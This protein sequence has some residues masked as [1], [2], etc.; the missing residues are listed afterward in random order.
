MVINCIS[1]KTPRKIL[2]IF[3]EPELCPEIKKIIADLGSR[4]GCCWQLLALEYTSFK[5]LFEEG[6]TVQHYESYFLE[7]DH[8]T[9]YSQAIEVATRWFLDA[10]GKDVTMYR[11]ISLGVII[12]RSMMQLINNFLSQVRT[13][14][15]ILEEEK[16][17]QLW[18]CVSP[19]AREWNSID[20]G[21]FLLAL[22][23][24]L[25]HIRTILWKKKILHKGFG[26]VDV[27]PTPTP[28]MQRCKS[29]MYSSVA[30]RLLFFIKYHLMM[31]KRSGIVNILLPSPQ[32]LNYVG[33]YPRDT[34][35]ADEQKNLLIWKGN[36]KRQKVNLIDVPS[37]FFYNSAY[38]ATD[39]V[40][41]MEKQFGTFIR[42][43]KIGELKVAEHLLAHLYKNQI[44]PLI[45]DTIVDIQQ[46][47]GLF[48]RTK[49]H[50]VF[51]HS[52]A[53][54]KE[55][56]VISVAHKEKVPSLVLQHGSAGHY[57]GFLPS[58]AIKFA[59]WGEIT[60][61]WFKRNGVAQEKVVVTGAANFDSY[62]RKVHSAQRVE[63]KEWNG[64]SDYLLYIAVTGKKFATGFKHTQYN[65]A[66][67][68]NVL[69]DALDAMSEKVLIIKLRPGDPQKAFYRSEIK[70]RG[71]NNV[72]L[73]EITDNERL[74]NACGLLLT[75][76]STM[77]IEGLFF[78]KPVIQLRFMNKKRLMNTLAQQGILCDEDVIPL[79]KYGAAIGVDNPIDLRKAI[80][81]I[82]EDD[83]LRHCLIN[84]GKVF[85][86]RYC[87]ELDGRA[88]LRVVQH[89]EQL[90]QDA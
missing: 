6:V 70:K 38:Q 83:E 88:S 19:A 41:K 80:L 59:A 43:Q 17:D 45:K 25:A 78:E 84:N 47:E 22:F 15:R 9:D 46:L 71:M 51:S 27:R 14:T 39:M 62:V 90:I 3:F 76:Y 37:F 87:Y 31:R 23:S 29:F 8:C 16:P 82:Y 53:T 77:A 36:T 21:S 57:W 68:L 66:L 13:I 52:D 48:K 63:K 73:I 7:E 42:S 34:I 30:C 61:E 35:L 55:R 65:N 56:T 12:E 69:L 33:Q 18:L 5:R 75:T 86:K 85:L 40:E 64:L 20:E 26:D 67:L 44:E 79:A 24:S 72:H 2:I 10:Q 54:L 60:E 1:K 11:D 50:L 58:I 74:L 28:F 4:E 32:A 49:I 89:I 81:N